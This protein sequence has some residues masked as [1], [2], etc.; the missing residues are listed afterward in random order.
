MGGQPE[1]AGGAVAA[2]RAEVPEEHGSEQ[3]LAGNSKDSTF[4]F[5]ITH[6]WCCLNLIIITSDAENGTIRVECLIIKT[7]LNFFF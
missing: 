3:L 4:S 5:L 2:Q 6:H 7:H 1:Q